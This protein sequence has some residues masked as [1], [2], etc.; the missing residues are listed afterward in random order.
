L[1]LE[2][3][4]GFVEDEEGFEDLEDIVE[5]SFT[6]SLTPMFLRWTDAVVFEELVR[7]SGSKV[8]S[9]E[10]SRGHFLKGSHKLACIRRKT[11]EGS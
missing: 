9:L 3:E 4:E 6:F 2:E 11:G 5:A 8:T 10:E 7:L 1:D